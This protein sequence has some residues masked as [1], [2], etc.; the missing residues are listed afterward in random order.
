MPRGWSKQRIQDRDRPSDGTASML[1]LRSSSVRK[2][3]K[4]QTHSEAPQLV[5]HYHKTP[6]HEL[7]YVYTWTQLFVQTRSWRIVHFGSVPPG[8]LLR[9]E[10]FDGRIIQKK[11]PAAK[12][13]NRRTS[14]HPPGYGEG[15]FPL[16]TSRSHAGG[17]PPPT[18]GRE[19]TLRSDDAARRLQ[20]SH[21]CCVSQG[22][23]SRH[24]KR[25]PQTR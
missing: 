16:D 7:I 21:C 3:F 9:M 18:C 22:S 8:C 12:E 25:F 5:P 13:D 24:F 15:M 14:A 17:D 19:L 1:L 10:T 2:N 11:P 23:Q 4:G 20:S 6:Y